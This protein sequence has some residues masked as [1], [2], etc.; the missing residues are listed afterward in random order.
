MRRFSA[1]RDAILPLVRVRETAEVIGLD[2]AECLSALQFLA[3]LGLLL[4]FPM[5]A[6]LSKYVILDLDTMTELYNSLIR[7]SNNFP[8]RV[9]VATIET[10]WKLST[11]L[12]QVTIRFLAEIGLLF[13]NVLPSSVGMIMPV[14]V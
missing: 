1:R 7:F 10:I 5:H 3:E 13:V 6:L 8:L 11:T 12:T 14:I 2:A 9:T 4:Y